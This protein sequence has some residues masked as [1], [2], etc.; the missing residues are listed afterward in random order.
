MAYFLLT[1][2]L[3]AFFTLASAADEAALLELWNQHIAAPE[4]H[5]R[6]LAACQQFHA[7]YANDPLRVVAR[8]LEEWHLFAMGRRSEAV[9]L[10]E[11]D[12]T[13]PPS[14]LNNGARRL[15]ASWLTRLDREAIALALRSYYLKHICYPAELSQLTT[16]SNPVLSNPIP[17]VDRFG[18]PWAY[19][20]T[21]FQKLKGFPDQ[22]YALSSPVLADMSDLKSVEK[23][24]Y[25]ARIPG[26][27]RQPNEPVQTVP[28]DKNTTANS[29]S[30]D[31][32][33][34]AGAQELYT[35]FA[36]MR[37]VILCDFIHWRVVARP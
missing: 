34:V 33:S 7:K 36:G 18:K 25:A 28:L 1:N 8:G 21:G 6:I 22:K 17:A 29:V 26:F 16:V 32:P 5:E 20:L 37:I 2:L 31:P 27:S 14:S 24:S 10:W 19:T 3:F 23:L 4:E 35:A 30:S 9:T 11:K 15:A 13:L 12:M